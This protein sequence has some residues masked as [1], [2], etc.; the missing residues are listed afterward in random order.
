MAEEAIHIYSVIRAGE[1]RSFGPVGIGKRE[2]YTVHHEGIAAVVSD[3]PVL[4]YGSMQKE[5]LIHHLTQ[6][7][8]VIERVMRDH[9]T[10][11]MKFG[12]FATDPD[13]VKKILEK[14]YAQFDDL[15]STM[16]GKIELDLVALWN[17]LSLIFKE[18]GEEEEIKRLKEEIAA[19]D[20]GETLKDRIK[21][22][23]RV[24]ASLDRKRERTAAEIVEVL[25]ELSIAFQPHDLLDDTMIMNVSFLIEREREREF[26]EVV[27]HLN[28]RC[29]E[30]INFRTIGPLPPYSFSTIEVKKIGF[31][32]IE[33]ARTLFGLQ[34]EAT[35]SEIQDV[36]RRLARRYHPDTD[37]TDP[38]RHK[39][40][41]RITRTYKALT[42]YC[43]HERCSFKKEDISSDGIRVTVL[44][45]ADVCR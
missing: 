9:T 17:D 28:R 34:E 13:E 29:H 39:Q 36:Y 20:P 7:Q 18:I 21:I 3:S 5:V 15:L 6:H 44:R 25:K 10:I 23:Q 22:G 24:K 40:F 32:E 33:E 41:E 31:E 11:P 27:N 45:S 8:S 35:T 30:K 14:G 4:S 12:T 16:D 19:R 38:E 1:K 43:Q 37:P 42:D 26:D 2:V